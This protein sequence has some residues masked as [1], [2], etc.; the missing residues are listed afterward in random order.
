MTSDADA[1]RSVVETIRAIEA[2]DLAGGADHHREE[3]RLAVEERGGVGVRMRYIALTIVVSPGLP[4]ARSEA[5]S[6]MERA[7]V[8]L[9]FWACSVEVAT[10]R[11]AASSRIDALRIHGGMRYFL[12]KAL[13]V[14]TLS[15]LHTERVG[16]RGEG[17]D[18]GAFSLP[19]QRRCESRSGPWTGG[20][21]L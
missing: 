12:T 9:I 1:E 4:S 15:G 5:Y 10:Q 3:D 21:G 7:R 13:E 11:P 14:A 18:E 16:A 20:S 17:L 2:L 6:R 19:I 8:P